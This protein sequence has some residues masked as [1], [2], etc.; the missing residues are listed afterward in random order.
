MKESYEDIRK[1]ES[2][3]LEVLRIRKTHIVPIYIEKTII[4]V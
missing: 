4:M 3:E 2:E 1:F